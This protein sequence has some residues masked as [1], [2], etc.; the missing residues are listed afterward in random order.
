MSDSNVDELLC[1]KLTG[2]P[3]RLVLHDRIKLE[4]A[5]ARRNNSQVSLFHLD[6]FPMSDIDHLFGYKVGKRLGILRESD[7]AARRR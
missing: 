4:L 6:P 7:T 2:L 5:H 1:D 3:S